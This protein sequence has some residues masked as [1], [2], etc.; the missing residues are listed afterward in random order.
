METKRI[1]HDTDL[2]FPEIPSLLFQYF[3]LLHKS[4]QYPMMRSVSFLLPIKQ[5]QKHP[6][7][8]SF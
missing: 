7:F 2:L 6:D 1:I 5:N 3:M 4:V 8:L